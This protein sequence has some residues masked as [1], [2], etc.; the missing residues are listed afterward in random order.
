MSK[1]EIELNSAGITEL[2]KSGEVMAELEA[3]ADGIISRCSGNYQKSVYRN[4]KTRGNVSIYTS[5]KE[6]FYRNLN[7]NELLTA[8]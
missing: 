6:T 3:Q 2:L 4:G 1:I 8:L 7:N 5:D